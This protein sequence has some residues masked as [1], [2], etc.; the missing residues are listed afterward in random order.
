[1]T[2]M[3]VTCEECG[4]DGFT[5]GRSLWESEEVTYDDDGEQTETTTN[6]YATV[7]T[8]DDCGTEYVLNRSAGHL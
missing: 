5:I 7:L 4:H 6:V 3:D 2:A 1:M 8:C